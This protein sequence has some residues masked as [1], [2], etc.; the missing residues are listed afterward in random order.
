VEWVRELDWQA[1]DRVHRR[2]VGAQG[3][4]GLSRNEIRWE[5]TLRQASHIFLVGPADD[6]RGY[7]ISRFVKPEG[8]ND[9]FR[10]RLEVLEMDWVGPEALRALLGFLSSQR[11]QVQEVVVSLPINLELE[12]ILRDPVTP[13]A[14][15]LPGSLTAGPTVAYGAMLRLEDPEAAFAG[16]P[17]AGTGSSKDR[18]TLRVTT[19]DPLREGAAISFQAEL[20]GA[21]GHP[22]RKAA[23][24]SARLDCGLATLAAIWAAALPV[25]RAVELGL[26]KVDPESAVPTLDRLLW[27]PPPWIV[28]KF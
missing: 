21:D 22:S 9:H 14:S 6:P 8:S 7:L 3:G 18:L 25:S 19:S 10:Y 13:G 2:S 26:A 12:M 20:G 23:A 28:E 27:A 4:L 11:D 15:E 24:G 5:W 1:L 17:Y 16:R